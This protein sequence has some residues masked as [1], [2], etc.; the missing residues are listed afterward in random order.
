ML[1]VAISHGKV[2]K[3]LSGI[4]NAED[5]GNIKPAVN[6]GKKNSATEENQLSMDVGEHP[7]WND[8]GEAARHLARLSFTPSPFPLSESPEVEPEATAGAWPE[9]GPDWSKA[10]G[11]WGAAWEFHVYL[12]ALIFLGFAVY[13]TYFIGH[14]LYVGLHQKYLGF[15]LNVV[16]LILGFTR[17]FVLFTDPYHQGDIIHNV[18]VMRVLWS[19]ASPCL[20]SADCLVILALV[21]TAKI[22][23]APQK[24]QKLSFVLIIIIVH[25][26]LVL[27]TDFVVSAFVEAKAMLVFCQAFFII[28][29]AILGVGYFVLG[30]KLDQKLFGHK[31]IKSRNEVLYIRL[32]FASGVNNFVLC[33]M[34]IYASASVFGV[35]SDV[36]IVDAWS[37]WTLQTCFRVSE[38][39]SGILVFTVSAKRK[40]LKK[41]P[42]KKAK[43]EYEVDDLN[44]S[45]SDAN[46]V[47]T[48]TG[49]KKERKI[50]MFSQM[51]SKKA[52]AGSQGE[53]DVLATTTVKEGN[54]STT[55]RKQETTLSL[56]SQLHST[57]APA[58]NQGKSDVLAT[59]TVQEGNCSTTGRKQEKK[60]SL[61]SQLHST[62]APAENQ[63]K[64]DLLATTSVQ[65]GNCST[66]GR[67]QEK[68]LSLFSQSYSKKAPAG[69]QVLPTTPAVDGSDH[70][71]LTDLHEAKIEAYHA[72]ED[73]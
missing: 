43:G 21:E 57:K 4:Q 30:Y 44:I 1:L 3:A 2:S 65:E 73:V 71:M 63:G 47:G 10:F 17:S 34:F 55:G 31:K 45:A 64:S 25:F 16:M 26:I 51:Y 69:N 42:D 18:S 68:K 28:W 62:K 8:S 70:N 49:K 46:K 39:S 9:P 58:E 50:S 72:H 40:S 24:M 11:E 7:K 14:G 13:A 15:C 20:T 48:A 56:F 12:F 33:T 53:N 22:S 59:T 52:P 38:V 6:P 37:W 67:K 32:I 60:L 19:L 66:T 27:V 5:S 36:K 61:F 41:K 35:Y 54:C 29:G 23:L